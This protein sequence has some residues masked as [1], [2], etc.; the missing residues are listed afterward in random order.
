[1]NH[2]LRLAP[3]VLALSSCASDA[4]SRPPTAAGVS[5]TE[6]ESEAC[7]VVP[8]Q[9]AAAHEVA[10][11][12]NALLAESR[13]AASQRGCAL[14]HPGAQDVPRYVVTRF[15]S[16]PRTNSLIV[17]SPSEDLPRILELIRRLDQKVE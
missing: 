3:I 1:M 15:V 7:E 6:S 4:G 10:A 8:L 16:D 13:V 2:V 12:L 11:T 14:A 9:H 17:R 5:A